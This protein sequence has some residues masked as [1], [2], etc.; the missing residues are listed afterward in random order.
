MPMFL[1]SIL[2]VDGYFLHPFSK[3]SRIASATQ[4]SGRGYSCT[5]LGDGFCRRWKTG[6][7]THTLLTGD[8]GFRHNVPGAWLTCKSGRDKDGDSPFSVARSQLL[9]ISQNWF[10]EMKFVFFPD[11]NL[12]LC[13]S[14]SLR[15]S[16]VHSAD[17]I[18]AH[19]FLIKR[20]HEGCRLAPAEDIC[21]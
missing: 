8:I 16:S 20:K 7:P 15:S 13:L 5:P 12:R 6:L 2:T 14:A 9:A 1:G 3:R 19:S 10:C 11:V 21:T 4:Q 17:T 18:S